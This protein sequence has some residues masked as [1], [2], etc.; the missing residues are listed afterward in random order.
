MLAGSHFQM[1]NPQLDIEEGNVEEN[2]KKPDLD[3]A[4]DKE[5]LEMA[6]ISTETP[7]TEVITPVSAPD[8][9]NKPENNPEVRLDVKAVQNLI[10]PPLVLET[11]SNNHPA[12]MDSQPELGI[13]SQNIPDNVLSKPQGQERLPLNGCQTF[14]RSILAVS[15]S[16]FLTLAVDFTFIAHDAVVGGAVMGLGGAFLGFGIALFVTHVVLEVTSHAISNLFRSREGQIYADAHFHADRTP[17]FGLWFRA[18]GNYLL[19]RGFGLGPLNRQAIFIR[20]PE[21]STT[22][23]WFARDDMNGCLPSLH[24]GMILGAI[25]KASMI[26]YD[27]CGSA[28]KAMCL[29]CDKNNPCTAWE[30]ML[31]TASPVLLW[32]LVAP[33]VD[34]NTL[35]NFR[36]AH[37]ERVEPY[38]DRPMDFNDALDDVLKDNANRLERAKEEARQD[39]TISAERR[40]DLNRDIEAH[41]NVVNNR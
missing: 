13:E 16:F 7:I 33:A 20:L 40:Q 38:D 36:R 12:V 1:V 37:T 27:I 30:I 31:A 23:T 35:Q 5:V 4:K 2:S 29:A 17:K 11:Q 28:C 10:G 14:G 26:P 3:I 41:N 6:P 25:F 39:P 24:G 9:V 32:L 15:G 21:E 8:S 22:A 18:E 19:R 34:G